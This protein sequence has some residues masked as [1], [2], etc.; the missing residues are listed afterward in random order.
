[1]SGIKINDFIIDE[2]CSVLEAMELLDIVATKVLFITENGCLKAVLT[3]GDIRR[4]ILKSGSLSESV[5]RIANYSPM[6]LYEKDKSF[7][8][9]Y[10]NK[11]SI[12]A[13][14]IVDEHMKLVSVSFL[15]RY[16]VSQRQNIDAKVVIMA[17]GFG[18]RLYPYTKILPKPLIPI[19]D[20]PIVERI[21]N[22]FYKNGFGEFFLILNYKKN[23]VK[24]YFNDIEKKYILNYV[25]EEK[26]LGTG[27]GLS[28][29]KGKIDGP[30]ILS[31][32]DILIEED[33]DKILQFHKDND[34][35]VTIVSSLKNIKIPYGVIDI[36]D[37]GEIEEMREKPSISVFV[38]TGMYVVNPRI[39]NELKDDEVI[40]F[41]EIIQRYKDDGERIGVY[42]VSEKSWLDMGQIDE[43][44]NMINEIG[45]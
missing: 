42:P 3:D 25:D 7:S 5:S 15:N 2:S 21:I 44:E 22:K 35:L 29:L 24:A 30:F 28:L 27:G 40:G 45:L 9:E 20:V 34:N 17:G 4:W 31:N 13:V 26:P 12:E 23:M 6:Y 32:C 39:I 14:P 36:N 38:N 41:P 11:N 10:M 8:K 1:M 19:G 33:Y 43:M 16:T 37:H 18:T